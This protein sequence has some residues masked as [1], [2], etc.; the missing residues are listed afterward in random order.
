VATR[1]DKEVDFDWDAASPMAGM[2]LTGFSVR[3]T[4]TIAAPGAGDYIFNVGVTPCGGRGENRNAV[5]GYRVYLDNKLVSEGQ[6]KAK[7]PF[8]VHFADSKPRAFRLEYTHS[9][10]EFGAGIHFEWQPPSDLLRAQAV[11]VAKKADVVVAFMG[12]SPRLEGEEM[13]VKLDGFSGGDRTKI[14]LPQQQQDLLK[15]VAA[16][17]KPL[18]LVLLNG[19][20]LALP[21]AKEHAAAILEAWYPGE[22]AG[23]AIAET[24]SGANDPSGRLPITFYASLDQLPPFDDYAMRGRTYR[25]FSGKPLYGF[26]YGLSYTS[27]VF[28][29]LKLSAPTIRAGDPLTV[30]AEVTN[31]GRRSGQEVAEL[32]LR[33]AQAAS[34]E[35]RS[36]RSFQRVTLAPGETKHLSFNLDSRRL[37]DVDESGN[38][39]ERAGSYT[40]F[41]GGGQPGEAQGVQAQFKVEGNEPLPR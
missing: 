35:I 29:G 14:D 22:A 15:A 34:G 1:L 39:A 6:C 19:S 31:T 4:G 30:E 5:E 3:W 12:L 7:Q 24:L 8:T 40:V 32:Y 13:P 33:G 41:V 25:Y 23:T 20:A 18:V 38:R 9:S 2:P 17:G 11:A 26:G 10:P 21:W 16:T 27:F 28:K 36:L 37:S